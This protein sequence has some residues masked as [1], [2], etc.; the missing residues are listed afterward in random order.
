MKKK[1]WRRRIVHEAPL[2]WMEFCV[3]LARVSFWLSGLFCREK[4]DSR[5]DCWVFLLNV[6]VLLLTRSF[7]MLS[8]QSRKDTWP[9]ITNLGATYKKSCNWLQ[10]QILLLKPSF[11]GRIILWQ[12]YRKIVTNS[13]LEE[14]PWGRRYFSFWYITTKIIP[15]SMLLNSKPNKILPPSTSTKNEEISNYICD[16]LCEATFENIHTMF[17]VEDRTSYQFIFLW[18]TGSWSCPQVCCLGNE[19]DSLWSM[20]EGKTSD[21]VSHEMFSSF[22][23]LLSKKAGFIGSVSV[24]WTLHVNIATMSDMGGLRFAWGWRHKNATLIACITSFP[25]NPSSCSFGSS[26]SVTSDLS[27]NFHAWNFL[28]EN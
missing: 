26:R 5:S 22:F 10:V 2:A 15:S 4:R 24:I 12:I 25:S 13:K 11:L 17:L 23:R 7:V 28:S 8:F 9:S 18:K 20:G 21:I 14:A 19:G 16:I 1:R 3:K 6:R 27:Y